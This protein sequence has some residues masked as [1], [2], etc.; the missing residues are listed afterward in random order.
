MVG[1]R[2][3]LERDN[4]DHPSK[5]RGTTDNPHNPGIQGSFRKCTKDSLNISGSPG[6]RQAGSSELALEWGSQLG[7]VLEIVLEIV[8]ESESGFRLGSGWGVQ[9]DFG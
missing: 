7:S 9:L 6:M 8:W 2:G 4:M 1:M 5:S 3:R